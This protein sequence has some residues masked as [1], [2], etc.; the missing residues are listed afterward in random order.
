MVASVLVD[1]PG[2]LRLDYEVPLLLHGRIQLG[3]RVLMRLRGRSAHG[4]VLS[5]SEERA[6]PS[7]KGPLQPLD[8]L[9]EEDPIL[10]P[11]L[12][13]LA[14]W[15]SD[16][17]LCPLQTVLKTFAPKAAWN[18]GRRTPSFAVATITDSGRDALT[19]KPSPIRG[20]RQK[21]V[22]E[23]LIETDGGTLP[24]NRVEGPKATVSSAAKALSAKGYL[25]IEKVREWRD[26]LA[27]QSYLKSENLVLNEHQQEALNRT[28]E[29][30]EAAGRGEACQPLLL[31][32][33]TGSGKTEV[34]LQAVERVIANGLSAIVLVPEISLTPQTTSRF[35]N[36]FAEI[37]DQVA[38]LHS[39]LSEGE[40]LDEWEKARSGRARIVIGPRSAIFAPLQNLGLIVVDEEHESSYKQESVPRYHGRDV[41]VYRSRLENCPVLLGSATP[42]LESW[43][44][45]CEKRYELLQLP[46]RIDDK[47][48][49]FVQ[50][51]DLR[52]EVAGAK[53]DPGMVAVSRPLRERINDRLAKGE[54]VMLFL[55]RRGFA[56]SVQCPD[57]GHVVECP[58]CALSLTY[59]RTE[60]RLLCHLC[61]YR[62]MPPKK[63][64]SCGEPGVR[65]AG[66]GTQRIEAALNRLFPQARSARVDA[67]AMSQ[68]GKLQS[69]LED[70]KQGRIDVLVGTQMIA[71]GLHFPNVTLVGVLHA[72]L[73]LHVPDFRANERVFQLLTQ[74]A[75]R[76]GRGEQPGEV[77][78]QAFT[79]Q[80][81]AIQ[82]ARHQDFPG[83][84]E[85]EMEHRRIM[86]FPPF[87]RALLITAR[88][89]DAPLAEQTLV[90]LRVRLEK[91]CVEAGVEMGPVLPSPLGKA[92]GQF[93]FQILLRCPSASRLGRLATWAKTWPGCPKEVALVYD[94][95]PHNLS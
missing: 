69:L 38:V 16:Y 64:D 85:Y 10:P 33:V 32:G 19:A 30:V 24:L 67:D 36:R 75:G 71:K 46:N 3:S 52:S 84:A 47:K 56:R 58:H 7:Y 8:D 27:D 88:S 51:I 94:V 45:V 40:R 5:I 43:H 86:S 70:F 79:P 72:D 83:F 37:Q 63:C 92:H 44:N 95:D 4:T 55:N 93:R 21:A 23:A 13:Q 87:V 17:Y 9:A 14:Q 39:G 15:V 59:H 12:F 77:I 89:E 73:G 2:E 31:W 11:S 81:E 60:D 22:L 29:V 6:D 49:P 66:F 18:E 78:I 35:K 54:Q 80:S 68:K 41:A 57:C 90:S 20:S 82:F 61:G 50:V 26:P 62:K 74:V 76:A 28:L 65:M 25:E 91:P 1:G 34:Y 42:S 53:G 48:L